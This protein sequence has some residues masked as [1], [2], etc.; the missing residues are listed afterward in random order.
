MMCLWIPKEMDG[1]ECSLHVDDTKG[2]WRWMCENF[3]YV[4]QCGRSAF[5]VDASAHNNPQ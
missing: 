3:S 2:P 5:H 4:V 1:S